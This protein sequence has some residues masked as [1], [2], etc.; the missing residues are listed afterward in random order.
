MEPCEVEGYFNCLSRWAAQCP[1][2]VLLGVKFIC[3]SP[4]TR[5]WQNQ[6]GNR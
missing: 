4:V 3:R 1:Y 6:S 2:S 5:Q